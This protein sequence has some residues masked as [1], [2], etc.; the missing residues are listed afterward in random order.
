MSARLLRVDVLTIHPDLKD[1][2]RTGHEDEAAEGVLVV[3]RDL[4]RQ[5]DGFFE[6]ASSGAVLDLE[7]HDASLLHRGP[8]RDPRRA[9]TTGC[10]MID[11][12]EGRSKKRTTAAGQSTEPRFGSRRPFSAAT[13]VPC[14]AAP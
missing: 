10:A 14:A 9:V 3:V 4:L 11:R 1:P 2:A 7:L 13:P 12:R 6:I 5:T 8:P